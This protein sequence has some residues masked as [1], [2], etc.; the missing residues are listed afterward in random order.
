MPPIKERRVPK[1]ERPA[2]IRE[3]GLDWEGARI[4]LEVARTGS[5]R[6][7]ALVVNQSVNALRRRLARLETSLGTTLLTR[8]VDGVRLTPEGTRVLA[9]A[10]RM[11]AATFELIRGINRL[12]SAAASEIKLAATEGLGTFW[13]APN[14]GEFRRRHPN[15]TVNLQFGMPTVDILRLEADIAIQLERPRAKDVKIMKLGRIHVMPFAAKSY[16]ESHG[17]PKSIADLAGHQA[18]Y[19]IADQVTPPEEYVADIR[20]AVEKGRAVIR[21][22]GS[23]AHFMAVLSGAGIGM[24]PTY[25]Q[26]VGSSA[27][28]P[29]DFNYRS[30]HDIWLVYHPDAARLERVQRMIEWLT[31]MFSPRKYP[32]FGDRF[33]HPSDLPAMAGWDSTIRIA[34]AEGPKRRGVKPGQRP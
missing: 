15:Q 11:E 3:Y 10:R 6:S 24:L 1:P 26:V 30:Q 28:V 25:V 16:V 17:V 29:L 32:W 19:Q 34:A 14:I 9:A 2:P 8:H 33:I 13:I 4:L 5:L 20:A 22:N 21:T 18:V 27:L 31:E 7:A 12:G 23:M